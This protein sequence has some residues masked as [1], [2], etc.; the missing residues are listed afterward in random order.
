MMKTS[1]S[2]LGCPSWNFSQILR[3]AVD[4]GYDGVEFRTVCGEVDLWKLSDFQPSA[5]ARTRKHIE[6][7]GILVSC[8]DTSACFHSP[9]V[10][11]RKG[12]VDLALRMAEIAAELGAPAIRVFGDRIQPGCSR[13]DTA[14]WIADSLTELAEQLRPENIEV[15][16]ETHGDFAA[17]SDVCSILDKTDDESIGVIWDPANAFAQT[18]DKPVIAAE[19]ADRVRHVHLKDLRRNVQSTPDYVL[20]G[21]GEFPFE[22]MFESLV[23]IGYEGF[24][25]FEWEKHWHP[26]LASPEVALPNFIEWWK[27][28]EAN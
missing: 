15:W 21:Q 3:A 11:E 19:M 9:G 23:Q 6:G 13:E 24:V 7:A 10:A 20:V 28:R 5:L 8:V 16:L 4:Y 2:T 18:G 25:S 17:A 12:N 26:E 27:R 1:F 22:T 14:K